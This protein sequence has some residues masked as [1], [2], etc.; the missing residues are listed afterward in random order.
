[1]TDLVAIL[2]QD[3]VRMQ[4]VLTE[5]KKAVL[6]SRIFY[7]CTQLPGKSYSGDGYVYIVEFNNGLLKVGRST[8][9]VKRVKDHKDQAETFGCWI[10][11]TWVSPPHGAYIANELRLLRDVARAS[12]AKHRS[13]YFLG[14]FLEAVAIAQELEFQD[15]EGV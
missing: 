1:M 12:K 9:P 4:I 11:R 6:V 3:L 13:E 8:N 2:Q 10:V 14:S 7:D 15:K 5:Q